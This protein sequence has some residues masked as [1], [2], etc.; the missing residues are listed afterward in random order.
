MRFALANPSIPM[1]LILSSRRR[2]SA[3]GTFS[4]KPMSFQSGTG[5]LFNVD[6]PAFVL[7]EPAGYIPPNDTAIEALLPGKN[8][9]I[10]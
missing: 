9:V 3:K 8:R 1:V 7:Y 4:S 5:E 10:N 6:L 2:S